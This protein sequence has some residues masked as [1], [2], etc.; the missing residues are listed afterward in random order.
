MHDIR[1]GNGWAH[2]GTGKRIA[3]LDLLRGFALLGILL[4]NAHQMFAPWDFA[5]DPIAL[6]AEERGTFIH[7]LFIDSFV[8][9][10]F[11]TLFSL[12]FGVGFA[13]Q[14]ASLKA[15][16]DGKYRLIYLRRIAFLGLLGLVH[17][18]FL[19]GADVL[20]YYAVTAVF[21][22]V[23]C[24]LSAKKLLF[25][26][27]ALTLI[28]MFWVFAL[29]WGDGLSALILFAGFALILL[30]VW[31]LRNRGLSTVIAG[32]SV[33]LLLAA[34]LYGAMVPPT[35]GEGNRWTQRQQAADAIRS[36][37]E[38][39][40]TLGGQE[41][42]I[43]LSPE[44]LEAIERMLLSPADRAKLT[45]T[46]FRDG[47]QSLALETRINQFVSVQVAFLLFYFWRTLAIFMIGVGLV[48]WGLFARDSR[49]LYGATIRWG[50]GIGVPLSLMATYL[51]VTVATKVSAMNGV[52]TLIHEA[53][54]YPIAFALAASVMLWS[55]SAHAKWLQTVLASAGRMALTN[56]IGQSVV[57]LFLASGLG[58][59][60]SLSRFGLSFL[61]VAVFLVL[62]L[63]S[64]IWLLRFRMGPL[65]WI[66]R[67]VTYLRTPA[68]RKD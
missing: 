68:H 57:M 15:K 30:T 26:G 51:K 62:A 4:V 28:V 32:G 45:T 55:S 66:W 11:L 35:I 8:L 40:I 48:K 21:L 7:W 36:Q 34:I 54:V 9:S 47:P 52:A 13:I 64:H 43:P 59:Y 14:I 33:S 65:E 27:F 38:G 16:H 19:Y 61:A 42:A 58:L 5:N 50:F 6:I 17:G 46:A 1:N 60:G 10:K 39:T 22:L 31:L 49:S 29:E 23:F 18:L 56:Y 12:L 37:D 63:A 41:F 24:E 25:S 3:G 67:A 53:S 20:T 2:I 44:D